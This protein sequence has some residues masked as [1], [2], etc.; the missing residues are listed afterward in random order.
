MP[1]NG[2]MANFFHC[3]KN[4]LK[5]VSDVWTHVNSVNVCHM[6]NIA[7]LLKKPLKWDWKK[8]QFLDPEAQALVKRVQRKGYETKV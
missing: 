1:I 6:A 3:V 4:K 2:H 5:P 8:Y 7:M